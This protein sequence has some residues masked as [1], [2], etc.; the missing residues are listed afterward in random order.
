MAGQPSLLNEQHRLLMLA[1]DHQL[2]DYAAAA[3]LYIEENGKE[4]A[5][6]QQGRLLTCR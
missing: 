6:E 4:W 2:A 5:T 1:A 3:E